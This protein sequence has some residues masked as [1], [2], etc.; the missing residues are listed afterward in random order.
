M[1]RTLVILENIR[2]AYNVGAIF[3]TADGAGVSKIY[4]VGYTPAPV[5]R[6]GREQ[7]EILKTSLGA[8]K[9]MPW[10][11][12]DSLTEII[13]EL[14]NESIKIVAVEQHVKNIN[15]SKFQSSGDRVF[16]FGNEVEGVSAAALA[17]ADTI[18][19]IPMSGQ[20]ES[21]NVSTAAG[22]ILFHFRDCT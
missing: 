17:A 20:K 18:I 16:I 2:S 8:S 22:I 19:N 10:E 9:T 13:T 11:K 14:R 1:A 7:P 6:F 21:L 5:D 15:Y 12:F 4:L 3:R